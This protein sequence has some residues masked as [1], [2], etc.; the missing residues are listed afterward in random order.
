MSVVS[1]KQRSL[2]ITVGV[3]LIS[4]FPAWTLADGLVR[5]M[6]LG[7]SIT[8]GTSGST[9]DTGYRRSLY[10]QLTNAGYDV[11]FVGSQNSGIPNDFD[12]DH[13][14]WS[15]WRADQIEGSIYTWLQSNPADIVLLHIGTN[16]ITDGD[17]DPNEISDILD[18]I[19]GYSEDIMVILSLIINRREDASTD[20]RQATT[21]FNQDV[22]DMAQSRI[23]AGDDI[24]I[25]DMESPLDYNMGVDMADQLHPNDN[26]YAKMA[27]VWYGALVDFLKDGLDETN[28]RLEFVASSKFDDFV[29]C[30]VANG[31]RLDVNESF[32]VRVDF[33]YSAISSRA[34]WVGMDISDGTNYVAISAGSGSN[35]PYFYY[36]A[37]VD[38][39]S[40]FEQEP[41]ASND[42]TLYCW[43]DADSNTVHLSH[44]GFD[45]NDAYLWQTISNPLPGQW[46]SSVDIAIG[47][48]SDHVYLQSGEA[49]LE[50]FEITDARLLDWPPKTDLDHNGYIELPDL[51]ELC[52]YWLETGTGIPA[53]FQPDETVDLKDLS[54]FGLAW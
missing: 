54:I 15:G 40:V 37:I 12:K 26:G 18:E 48:V 8:E 4:G 33:H 30:Y 32:A 41:R 25:V 14:G 29:K 44:T 24:I 51:A 5:I 6:P 43:Y 16:D 17:Q 46:L 20:L 9:D 39:N 19:D 36:D 49:Y 28:Q 22:N 50:N 10:L 38:G 1:L 47:G 13:E 23:T 34:G 11:N 35:T 27:D 42:G 21:Q 7:D 2:L 53:D 3:V 31:W 52:D 45:S